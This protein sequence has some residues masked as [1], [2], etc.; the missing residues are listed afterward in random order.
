A[1]VISKGQVNSITGISGQAPANEGL[2]GTRR[3]SPDQATYL[4]RFSWL[5]ASPG[6]IHAHRSFSA[7]PPGTTWPERGKTGHPRSRISAS[8]NLI[9][10]IRL[11]EVPSVPRTQPGDRTAEA[12]NGVPGGVGGPLVSL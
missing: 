1:T 10:V 6:A 5:T 11:G 8:H 7:F 12:S 9:T 4:P 3:T 2:Y